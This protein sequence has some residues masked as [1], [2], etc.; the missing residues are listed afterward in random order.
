MGVCLAV[1]SV[2]A[3]AAVNDPNII[4]GAVAARF[5]YSNLTLGQTVNGEETTAGTSIAADVAVFY[6]KNVDLGA[7]DGS[8]R[9]GINISNI[10]NKI[11]YSKSTIKKDFKIIHDKINQMIY[12]T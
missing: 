12:E 5:I 4:S 2:N 8:V 11:S 3:L 7:T 9:W 6:Q 10:G 1:L